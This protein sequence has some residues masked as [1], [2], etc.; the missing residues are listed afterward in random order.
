MRSA[1]HGAAAPLAS[2]TAMP[3]VRCM[4]MVWASPL[5]SFVLRPG[6]HEGD[7]DLISTLPL[8]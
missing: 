3:K 1:M 4:R 2:L 7:D 8:A 5:A 6:Q